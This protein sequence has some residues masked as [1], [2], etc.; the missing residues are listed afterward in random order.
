MDEWLKPAVLKNKTPIRYL[1]GKSIKFFARHKITRI[2]VPLNLRH[3][4][5]C[6]ASFS[7]NLVAVGDC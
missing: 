5:S 4:R 1:A 2:F 6:C 3:F 7:D